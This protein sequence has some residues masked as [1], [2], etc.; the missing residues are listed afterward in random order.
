MYK[1]R[2]RSKRLCCYRQR[3]YIG[4]GNSPLLSRNCS[5][6]LGKQ[7]NRT[8]LIKII[9]LKSNLQLTKQTLD[10]YALSKVHSIIIIK[11][12]HICYSQTYTQHNKQEVHLSS[13]SNL[14]QVGLNQLVGWGSSRIVSC[15]IPQYDR[16]AAS[17]LAPQD[18]L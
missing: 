2:Y 3:K 14:T 1:N 8:Y 10:L 7:M 9:L 6:L 18:P 4:N 17:V 16:L 12:K 11:V 15:M 5:F 13:S